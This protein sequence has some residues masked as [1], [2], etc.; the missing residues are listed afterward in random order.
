VETGI[1]YAAVRSFG[2]EQDI[3]QFSPLAT[4]GKNFAINLVTGGIGGKEK[5]G[6][7]AARF[8]SKAVGNFFLRQGV[9]IAG[10]T[11]FDVAYYDR[12]LGSALAYN[13]VGSL[14]GEG[15]GRAIGF[16][17][18]RAAGSR[19]G[20]AFTAYAGG[21][22]EGAVAQSR[23]GVYLSSGSLGGA[24]DIFSAG[25]QAGKRRLATRRVPVPEGHTR[26]YRAVS[27]AEYQD[28][29]NTGRLRQGPN[30]LEGKWFADTV[31]GVRL[32]GDALEG[33][34]NYRIIEVD[35]PNNAPSLSTR[36]NLD[37]RGPARYLHNDD[38]PALIPRLFE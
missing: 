18:R 25:H 9:E 7:S 29:L 10:D 28:I 34:G 24:G 38:L 17:L 13:T 22:V 3:Q 27:E 31:E 8:T 19:A 1:E 20:R 4:F 11:A 2:T 6:A 26:V 30:S 5:A 16:G 21:F 12:D 32:H 33:A 14:L 35:I 37:G 36:T 15:A 23:R